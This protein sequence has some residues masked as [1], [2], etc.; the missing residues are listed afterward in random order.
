MPLEHLLTL[1]ENPLPPLEPVAAEIARH[2]AAVNRYPEFYPERLKGVIADWLG[3][4]HESVVV[5]SGSVGVALQ[6]LQATVR[7]GGGLAYAWRNFDAYP[8]LAGMTGARPLEV[9]LLTSG[10]QDLTGLAKASLDADAVIVCNPH[11]PT[12]RFIPAEELREF[13]ALVPADTLVVLDEA[14]MEFVDAGEAAQ[15]VDWV[16]EHPNLLVLRTFSKAYGLADMRVG[17]GV[18]SPELA[19]RINAFQLPFSMSSL[20]TVAVEASL[21]EQQALRERVRSIVRE[22]NRVAQE[23][24]R[25]GWNVLPSQTNFL[26]FEEPERVQ[27]IR[28]ALEENG[29]LAR[30]FANE[31][32]RLTIGDTQANAAVLRALA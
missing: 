3:V 15:S 9:P 16:R 10:H 2:V 31:G 23:L 27:E 5:G 17:Y 6:A 24:L 18:T 4:P 29:V 13:L 22:R 20:S 26:W 1:N 14:Y 30:C 12:G 7:S 8:L 32:V 28:A 19:R 25:A 11:N 21:R